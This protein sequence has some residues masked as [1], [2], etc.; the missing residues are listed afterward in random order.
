MAQT[1]L[2]RCVGAAL[3]AVIMSGVT[4]QA[5][6]AQTP[7]AAGQQQPVELNPTQEVAAEEPKGPSIAVGPAELRIGGYLGVTG[8]Y[9]SSADG[10]GTGTSFASIPYGDTLRGNVS[11]TRLTAQASRITLRI[12]AD[13]PEK[14]GDRPRF[15]KLAG[16]FEMDF[17][18]SVPDTIAVTSTSAGFRLRHAFAEVR[19]GN[20]IYMG[21]GQAFSLMTPQ[22][23]QISIWPSD[24]EI[25]QAVDTNYVAGLVW[26]RI[27]QVRF[28]WRP[29][30]RF[31][32]AVSL[33]NP[34]QQLGD[35]LVTLPSCCASDLDAQ[36]NTG[37]AGLSVPNLM[38]DLITRVA[39]NPSPAV[40]L[41]VGGVL[42]VFRHTVAPYDDSD[43]FATTAGGASV[44]GSVH[45]TG[46]T[47][48][49]GQFAFGP[50]IGRYI[51]GLVPDATFSADSSIHPLR[52]TSWVLGVEQRLNATVSMAGYYSGVN[53][54]ESFATDADGGFIGFGFPGSLHSSNRSIHEL[55]VTAALL[56]FRSPNRG[57][58]QVNVQYSWLERKPFDA[59]NGPASAAMHMFFAQ[60]R[61]N[62]P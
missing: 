37:G 39:F 4:A 9:R 19:Y 42:R 28:A 48:M 18:G 43:D 33:E 52:T 59:G 51:G 58:A 2:R 22:K 44:N 17:N 62:L 54:S 7:A 26:G 30:R 45:A 23:D 11:E 53:T 8:F 56:S 10:G 20:S 36:Y 55:T 32:W 57:S 46:N 3:A 14:T 61:Y 35:S 27:P 31:N 41:D 13:F 1:F 24:V 25:S 60:V 12:D 15:R 40:H 50:G 47:K 38:P 34:E 29:A 21:V 49:I 16:Y 6:A 5:I